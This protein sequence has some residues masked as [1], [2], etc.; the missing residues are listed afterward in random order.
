[1]PPE[2]LREVIAV[3]HKCVADI[4][5]QLRAGS[6]RK[7]LGDGMLV[8]FG[9]PQAHEDDAERAVRAGLDLIGADPALK[10]RGTFTIP[11]W[12]CHRHWSCLCDPYVGSGNAQERGIVG[13]TP[14]FAALSN[15]AVSARL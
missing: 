6:W 12:H 10:T 4:V 15:D 14:N 1:M 5:R 13:E 9:Y 8:Y 7:Y 11:H 3:Y 2:D